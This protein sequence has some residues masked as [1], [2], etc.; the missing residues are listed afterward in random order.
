LAELEKNSKNENWN[1]PLGKKLE[2]KLSFIFEQKNEI[3]LLK[4]VKNQNRR[5]GSLPL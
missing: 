3:D 2:P 1:H 4:N 5:E